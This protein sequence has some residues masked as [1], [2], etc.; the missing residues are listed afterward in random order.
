[1][2]RFRVDPSVVRPV[3]I[4]RYLQ[5]GFVRRRIL[6]SAKDAVNQS[7]IN[8][9]DVRELPVF[10]PPVR[11]QCDFEERLEQIRGNQQTHRTHL[12]TLDELFTSL[13]HR[14]FSGI[15]WDHEVTGEAA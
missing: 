10:L 12:A 5:S 7:S 1:M 6:E 4:E 8:Q 15:L 11:R 13:Q 9:R 14:A 3:F 2:M